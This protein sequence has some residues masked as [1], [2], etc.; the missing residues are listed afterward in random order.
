MQVQPQAL[1]VGMGQVQVYLQGDCTAVSA[2]RVLRILLDRLG[3]NS[4]EVSEHSGCPVGLCCVAAAEGLRPKWILDLEGDTLFEGGACTVGGTGGCVSITVTAVYAVAIDTTQNKVCC[5]YHSFGAAPC[6]CSAKPSV[7]ALPAA[8][9]VAGRCLHTLRGRPGFE[10]HWAGCVQPHL[11]GVPCARC[12][13]VGA[14]CLPPGVWRGAFLAFPA[15]YHA[16][17]ALPFTAAAALHP[18]SAAAGDGTVRGCGR[19]AQAMKQARR[20]MPWG[21]E[22]RNNTYHT[23]G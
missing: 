18:S 22:A 15:V 17:H 4:K 10:H 21:W 2:M 5:S 12:G 23:G 7:R 1:L 13:Y 16:R 20:G 3:H 14:V 8:A 9:A 19:K 11:P 6:L